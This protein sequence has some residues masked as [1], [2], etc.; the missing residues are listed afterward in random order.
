[1]EWVAVPFCRVGGPIIWFDSAML[2]P[3]SC[4]KTLGKFQKIF[5]RLFISQVRMTVVPAIYAWPGVDKRV[6]GEY[7]VGCW[8][9]DKPSGSFNSCSWIEF[10]L[11]LSVSLQTDLT[12]S[13]RWMLESQGVQVTSEIRQQDAHPPFC[14]L[15]PTAGYHPMLSLQK[16]QTHILTPAYCLPVW[17][18]GLFGQQV[19]FIDRRNRG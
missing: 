3:P 13:E 2:L 8:A 14:L 11:Y 5:L 15:T 12:C 9:C 19:L 10:F 16:D 18:R 17:R 1:M 7:L 4:C 6:Q